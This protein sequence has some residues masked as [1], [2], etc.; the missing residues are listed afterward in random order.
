MHSKRRAEKAQRIP[1]F[2]KLGHISRMPDYRRNR[3]PGGTFFFT[4][5]LLDRN[6]DLLVA[7]IAMLR[8]A[9]RRVRTRAPFRIDAWVVLPDHMHCQWT[10]T[11]GPCRQAMPP[12]PVGGAQSK[13]HS[14]VCLAASLDHR[15]LPA[16]AN[17]VFGSA[18]I[19]STRYATIGTLRPTWTTRI[20]TR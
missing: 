17:G 14:C 8:D 11:W 6:S 4:V 16:A 10:L 1:P 13:P 3:V 20:L 15:S 12:S 7:Q 19:G 2:R 5:N 9:V 18:A